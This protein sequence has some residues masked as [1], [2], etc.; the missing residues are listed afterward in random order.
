MFQTESMMSVL[1]PAL[2]QV[3]ARGAVPAGKSVHFGDSHAGKNRGMHAGAGDCR[4]GDSRGQLDADRNIQT[5]WD[6]AIHLERAARI[7]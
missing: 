2:Q 5:T 3:V 1:L 4:T 6:C 7:I